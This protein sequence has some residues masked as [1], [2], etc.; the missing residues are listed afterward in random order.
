MGLIDPF[1]S[2][3]SQTFEA[4]VEIDR[5]GRLVTRLI[6]SAVTCLVLGMVAKE[7]PV[8]REVLVVLSVILMTAGIYQLIK[9]DRVMDKVSS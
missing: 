6:I 4:Q 8:L 7:V 9:L 2:V 1:A 3:H 5:R